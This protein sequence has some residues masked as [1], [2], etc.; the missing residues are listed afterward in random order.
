MRLLVTGAS[1][2]V[3]RGLLETLTACGHGGL[4]TGREPPEPVPAA[5]R[6]ARRDDVLAGQAGVEPI[7]A[8]VHLEVKH[9]VPRP[10]PAD[11][12]VF[13]D[14]NVVGT[15]D[16]LA[17]SVRHGVPRFV[18]VSSIKAT[19]PG[20]GSERVAEP[21]GGVRTQPTEP[22]SPYGRTKALAEAAVRDWAATDAGRSAVILRPA[23]VYGPGNEANFAAFVRQILAGRPCLIGAGDGVKSVVS[24]T[25]LVAAIAFALT[26]AAP[27]CEVYNVSDRETLS[28]AQLAEIIAE[29]SHS[30]RPRR[31]PG[32]L[33]RAIAVLGDLFQAATGAAFPLT[34]E[35][36][37][38][39][40][41]PSLFPCTKLEAAG[42]RHPQTTRQGLAEMLE[43]MGGDVRLRR[44]RRPANPG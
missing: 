15:R 1:G 36:M 38:Q 3:G 11:M 9:H 30:P 6:A 25:N 31:I 21:S 24:R 20:D 44:R 37:H 17:W 32:A 14:V 16:W 4:A 41:S 22:D 10:T 8:V 18:L 23:P 5:W 19:P 39:I 28:L 7:D 26:S 29:L 13:H 42:F 35:R 2:F 27:G 40:L 43:W 12:R 34:T 33:A